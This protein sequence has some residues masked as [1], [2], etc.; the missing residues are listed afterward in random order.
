MKRA[1]SIVSSVA[2]CVGLLA[3][4]FSSYA[5]RAISDARP[6][7]S[8]T[9]TAHP[10][11]VFVAAFREFAVRPERF[12]ASTIA[13]VRDAAAR[14]PLASEPFFILGAK[15]F[16]DNQFER[17]IRL[18][19][20]ARD[21]APNNKIARLLL[22]K[23]FLFEERPREA[24]VELATLMRIVPQANDLLMPELANFLTT[25]Q[26]AAATRQALVDTTMFDRAMEYMV[27]QDVPTATLLRLSTTSGRAG[28][29][30][31]RR[32]QVAL[33]RRLINENREA[34]AYDAWL[35][36]GKIQTEKLSVYDG[37]FR[38]MPG[39]TPFNWSFEEN[40]VGSAARDVNG[41][42]VTM[43]G[44]QGGKLA[45]QLLILDPGTYILET[46]Y[47]GEAN[48]GGGGTIG[49]ELVCGTGNRNVVNLELSTPS[50]QGQRATARFTVPG[51]CPI[52]R[53]SLQAYA[54]D[55]PFTQRVNILEVSVR[56]ERVPS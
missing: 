39:T 31:N 23:L 48:A 38:G 21:R 10:Q 50:P 37:R 32:W 7:S 15:A 44:R 33:I 43:Y 20:E 55:V 5:G 40:A 18:L 22:A 24:A 2:L 13:S 42:E 27:K 29:L 34:S 19:A 26:T 17:S 3:A 9:G 54:G 53:L 6:F 56:N 25:P 28:S 16:Q 47:S 36:F 52:Q 46:E 35:R 12:N 51:N 30:R 14:E 8:L 49:W 4:I 1:I 45:E 41:L 11:P